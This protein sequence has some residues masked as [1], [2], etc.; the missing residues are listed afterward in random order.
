M[1]RYH[2]AICAV[3]G[4]VMQCWSCERENRPGA[5]FCASCGAGLG[6]ANC[7]VP[8]APGQRFCTNC[9]HR[10]PPRGAQTVIRRIEHRFQETP[11]FR[12]QYL[13]GSFAEQNL[14]GIAGRLEGAYA[15]MSGLLGVDAAFGAGRRID[16]FLSEI[17]PD[18][19]PA[20][21]PP[22]TDGYADTR[23]LAIYAAFR[24]D[25]PGESLERSLLLVLLSLATGSDVTPLPFIV[26]G[27]LFVTLQRIG[28]F[29]PPEALV[30]MLGLARVRRELPPLT[31]L[32]RGPLPATQ[33]IYAPAVAGFV[34]FLLRTYGVERLATFIRRLGP[35]NL[36]AAAQAAFG[37]PITQIERAWHKSLRATQPGGIF[38]FLRLSSV[39]LRP[40]ALKVVEIVV[41]LALASLFTTGLAVIQRILFDRALPGP[42]GPGS[43]RVLVVVMAALVGGF[44]LVSLTSLREGYLMAWVSER[45]IQTIRMRIFANLQRLH[46]GFFQQVQSGD[47]LSR[48]TSD[49]Q[50][51]EFALTGALAQ[52]VRLAL[53][54]V[55]AVAAIFAQDWKLA[56]IAMAGMPLF[57]VTGRWLGPAA[58]RASF[59]R[60]Q[61]LGDATSVL[62]ENLSAQPVV[63]AFGLQDYE[64]RKYTLSLNT[65]FRSS[66]RLTF[67]SSIF[68]LSANSIASGIQL[69]VLGLGGYL[70]LEGNLTTGTLIAFLGLVS[71]IISPVQNSSQILQSLQ[72][73]TGAMDRV[74]ELMRARPQIVDRPNARRLG[75]LAQ[76]I[77]FE[78]VGFSYTP[79]QPTLL[80]LSLE[81]PAG[82][83]VALVGPSGCGKSTVLNLIMR[84]YDPQQGRVS[85]D[86][87]DL[88]DATLD[89]VRGQMGVVFQD[90]FLF[91]TTIRENIRL[92]RLDATDAEVEEA[93]RAAEIHDLILSLPQGYDTVV[94]ERGSRLSGGQR[95]R[96]AIA[97][98]IIRN[99]AIL[100]LDEATSAL[101][102]RTEAAINDTLDR[103][104][105]GRTT[106]AV[107][108]RLSSVVNADRIYVLDR[109]ALVEQGT[110]D[111]L[112]QRGG[113][114]AR[115][116]QEQ[117]GF[118]IGAGVQYVGVEA[119][120]LQSVPLFAQF[121]GDLLAALAQ[122]LAVERYPAGD[123]IVN[124]GEVGDR[125]YIIQRG[126]VEVLAYDPAGP[127]RQLAVLHEGDYFGEVALL[128]DVPRTA[129][130]RA[131]TPVQLYSLTRLDFNALLDAVPGLRESMEQMMSR[132]ARR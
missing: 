106:I 25:S 98:A 21:L 30:P 79:Q 52:G 48:M 89:S 5:R 64:N 28:Q 9:G 78:S 120:R 41:Y 130:I 14:A 70:V 61:N 71:Q 131:L 26:D 63:K 16:V 38:R 7:G 53:T 33:Q 119:S 31:T 4:W 20:G 58:A 59:E 43:L 65:L 45:V 67:L 51:I 73:A 40:H 69:L 17:P 84:F 126:Q 99:P 108:H 77:R 92:G 94:G 121:D 111:E 29:P 107:T 6:C 113:L 18:P 85:F 19:T 72:Q 68:G 93:A 54:F 129:T 114:Y 91:N 104:A 37:R 127:Q 42:N 80:N 82:A 117:G 47:I 76:G 3:P 55:L 15:I 23:R 123:V 110:H 36:E 90:N 44:L 87:V 97:R 62:Q 125:L 46:P 81:I 13:I 34:G 75:P 32:L 35:S 57:F 10:S 83:S 128:Y 105:R 11:H 60:Q 103:L 74:E 95:Q 122:R 66:I 12:I 50:A 1:L 118:V 116:W 2:G 101:D 39:Y 56:L 109:G 96:V 27:L 102:P 124:E 49:L 100:L 86:G 88:R 132:Y 8:L 112:V 115:L 24:P 22:G